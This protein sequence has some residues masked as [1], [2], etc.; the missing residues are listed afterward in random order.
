MSILSGS[1]RES[2]GRRHI[3]CNKGCM[4]YPQELI[5]IKPVTMASRQRKLHGQSH[6]FWNDKLRPC[7]DSERVV[8][9]KS[10]FTLAG[11]AENELISSSGS[12]SRLNT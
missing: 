12:D 11:K 7:G 10:W 8:P 6:R 9:L 5:L 2:F 1:V 3:L 4:D